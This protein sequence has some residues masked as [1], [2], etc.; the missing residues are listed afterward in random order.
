MRPRYW[1]KYYVMQLNDKNIIEYEYQTNH[2]DN[3]N[4]KLTMPSIN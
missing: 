1:F 4:F 2:P 3:G